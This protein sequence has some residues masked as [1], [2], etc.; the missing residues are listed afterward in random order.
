V[1]DQIDKQFNDANTAPC[2]SVIIPAYN[3]AAHLRRAV[4]SALAQTMPDLEIIIVDDAST[5][6]TLRVAGRI[7]SQ[8]SRVRVLHNERNAGPSVSRNRAIAA[9]RGEWIAILDADDSWFPERLERMLAGAGDADVVSDDLFIVRDSLFKPDEPVLWSMLQAAG[10]MVTRPRRLDMLDLV[11]YELAL[12]KPI[13]RRSFLGRHELS[14]DPTLLRAHDFYLYFEILALGGRWLQLPQGY[15]LYY[16]HGDAAKEKDQR[17]KRTTL[18]ETV[19]SNRALLDHPAAVGDKALIAALERRIQKAQRRKVFATAQDAVR[20]RRF[21]DFARWLV[22]N[23]SDLLL[24]MR[25]VIERLYL[26]A[27]WRV[28]R[29]RGPKPPTHRARV[30][31]RPE[32]G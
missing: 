28:Y 5:D 32:E 7:A 19:E 29:L 16:K 17:V 14:Y 30:L 8:D 22:D 21:A 2:V 3:A 23:P 25:F 11:R 10:F 27:M 18:T 12:L 4:D 1:S 15:Y 13:L 24:V 26:R 9:A 20:Q 6:A 31:V